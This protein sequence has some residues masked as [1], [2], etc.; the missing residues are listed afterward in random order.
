MMEKKWTLCAVY[1]IQ[2]QL[3]RGIQEDISSGR[4]NMYALP[5]SD[6]NLTCQLQKRSYL[7]QAQWSKVTHKL[8]PI[9]IYHPQH[10]FHCTNASSFTQNEWRN[11]HT[12]E[13]QINQTLEIPCFQNISSEI[14]SEFTF[15]WLVGDNGTQE[16]I[17]TQGQHISNATSFTDR[18]TLGADYRLKL[19]P[20][21]T[22]DDGRKF[23]CHVGVKP[24]KILKS[25]TVVKVFAKPETPMI[26]ENKTTDVLGK[27]IFTCSLKKVFPKANISWFIDGQFLQGDKEELQ[28][29]NEEKKNKS[30]FLELKSI[31]TK[32]HS[33]KPAQSNNLTVW[34]MASFPVPGNKA[35]NTSSEKITVSLGSVNLPTGSPLSVTES[36][37]GTQP[38][39]ANSASPTKDP[40]TS[41]LVLIDV[42]TSKPHIVPQTSNSSMTNQV[43]SDSWTSSATEDKKLVSWI[44]SESYSSSTLGTGS[45]LHGDIITST[46]GGFSE[47]LTTAMRLNKNNTVYITD[48]AVQK[49]KDG[50]SWPV[51]VAALLAFCV[52]LFGL[53]LRKWCQYLREI[54]ERPPPFKPPPPPI[55]YTC[56]HEPMGSDLPC[57]EMETLQSLEIL[58]CSGAL[59]ES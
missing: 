7:V 28:I 29:T 13:I 39:P 2:I 22:H 38:S 52:V 46:L 51:M 59:L 1:I 27:S 12:I 53:G 30:G 45:S 26:T 44:P 3:V 25:S 42:T 23:S 5:G 57:H 31:L 15:A 18:V 43:F 8:D 6:I 41:S 4:E 16:T 17:I 24:G 20:V 34:C 21:Q 48:I 54:M 50:M 40:A 33:N 9:A 14:L 11:N 35:W 37:L 32:M 19:F 10:G 55:E 56:I 36:T 47:I 58:A 49:T